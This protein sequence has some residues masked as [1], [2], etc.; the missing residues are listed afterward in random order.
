MS[1]GVGTIDSNYRGELKAVFYKVVPGKPYKVGDRIIQLV[2]NHSDYKSFEIVFE[3]VDELNDSK[4]G[5]GG[6]GSTGK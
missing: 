5:L 1:N 3:E 4:R 2:V 6:F